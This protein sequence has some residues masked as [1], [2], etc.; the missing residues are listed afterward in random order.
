[1]EFNT[2][3]GT[4]YCLFEYWMG[5]IRDVTDTVTWQENKYSFALNPVS[6]KSNVRYF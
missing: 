2:V 4:G 1:M 6:E 5:F 3:D